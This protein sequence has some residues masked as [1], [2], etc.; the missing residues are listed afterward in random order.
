MVADSNGIAVTIPA[1]QQARLAGIFKSLAEAPPP[2]GVAL[3]RLVP[4]TVRKVRRVSWRRSFG[5]LLRQRAYRGGQGALG[6]R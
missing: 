5:A 3:A 2:D 4:D 6:S 1:K